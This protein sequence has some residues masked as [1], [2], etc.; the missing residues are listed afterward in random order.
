MKDKTAIRDKTQNLMKIIGDFC[1][2]HLDDEYKQ[3]CE[4][5][6]QKMLRKRYVPFIYGKIEIWA[7]AVIYSIGT[8]NFLFD[9]SFKPYLRA[10][11]ICNYFG[12][13]KSTTSQKSKLIRDTLKL[14]YWDDEFS[15]AFMKEN[16]P[17]SDL[18]MINGMIVDIKSLPLHI[19]KLY[20]K[21]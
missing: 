10:D 19:Q 15:T 17:F 7:S 9:K 14:R 8:I 13:S 12:T 11:D 6:I 21:K 4:K 1:D 5:L 20:M 16:N 3:L 18:V 2:A